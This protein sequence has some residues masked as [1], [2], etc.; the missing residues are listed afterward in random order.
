M[1]TKR[2]EDYLEAIYIIGEE[3]GFVRIKD[4]AK[5]VEVKPSTVI[6]ML[7]KL[8]E[9]G[10]VKYEKYGGLV[11]THEGK[12]LAK[13]IKKRHDVFKSFLELINIPSEIANKD[14]CEMEHKLNPIT[15]EQLSHFVKFLEDEDSQEFLKDFEKYCKVTK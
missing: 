14:A 4:I 9:Q 10:Y 8:N 3:K 15:V 2:T 13:S 12:V 7:L 5:E 1:L 11:M 6:E